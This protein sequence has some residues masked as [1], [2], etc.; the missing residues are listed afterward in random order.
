MSKIF[1]TLL[2][3]YC[4]S[5][6]IQ[7]QIVTDLIKPV[8]LTFQ[9]SG[10]NYDLFKGYSK[11]SFS[12][13]SIE[14]YN[15]FVSKFNEECKTIE[16]VV[17]TF[18]EIWV[19]IINK[20][21]EDSLS[22]FKKYVPD[23]GKIE[24]HFNIS[25]IYKEFGIYDIVCDVISQIS[26]KT[27]EDCY[28]SDFVDLLPVSF[29]KDYYDLFRKFEASNETEIHSF[30][31]YGL[32]KTIIY[33]Y[34][35]KFELKKCN[36]SVISEGAKDYI[37]K[38]EKIIENFKNHINNTNKIII[39]LNQ[40]IKNNV[41]IEKNKSLINTYIEDISR[42]NEEIKHYIGILNR[43]K[44][45]Y[46]ILIPTSSKLLNKTV[47]NTGINDLLIELIS[48]NNLPFEYQSYTFLNRHKEN[49]ITL[50]YFNNTN[51]SHTWFIDENDDKIEICDNEIHYSN[52]AM[53]IK[54]KLNEVIERY[55]PISFKQACQNSMEFL[56]NDMIHYRGDNGTYH[57]SHYLGGYNVMIA[58]KSMRTAINPIKYQCV[59][60]FKDF[61]PCDT[62]HNTPKLIVPKEFMHND[63]LYYF[64][65]MCD[66][67]QH[68]LSI[69]SK[70]NKEKTALKLKQPFIKYTNEALK[71]LK[72][73][74][75]YDGDVY[76]QLWQDF[77]TTLN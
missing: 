3:G 12:P 36:I 55:N 26:D 45:T 49:L 34:S 62:I 77:K 10:N 58:D 22:K 30:I 52:Y 51:L 1:I 54:E 2:D 68:F 31:E 61:I 72:E 57:N 39:E 19:L 9:Y 38:Q 17:P 13:M 50:A 73:I 67:Y 53:S 11:T 14:K 6:F 23:H 47:I 7:N 48:K 29:V 56:F 43:F 66:K 15:N 8:E 65:D 59:L 28:I 75:S 35:I 41:D 60:E 4:S 63:M 74:S 46:Q 42:Y 18:E 64:I 20:L 32:N 25:E 70:I 21:I 40:L 24:Y 37:E 69:S 33:T 44:N 16:F 71:L 27:K 76:Y 5:H